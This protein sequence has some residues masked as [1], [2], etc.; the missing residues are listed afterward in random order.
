V[1]NPAGSAIVDTIGQ[2]RQ[3]VSP[4]SSQAVKRRYLV[5]APDGNASASVVQIQTP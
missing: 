4:E 3:I 5:I 2:I 1:T